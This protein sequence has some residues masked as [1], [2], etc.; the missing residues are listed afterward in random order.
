[1]RLGGGGG[2]GRSS[3]V[4]SGS[5][6]GGGSTLLSIL[7]LL[8]GGVDSDLDGNR[9]TGNLLAFKSGDGLL[10]VLLRANVDEA[11]AL[12]PPGLAPAATDD[13]SRD[14]LETS[15]SEEGGEASI[16]N[17]EA[18][19][20][21]EEHVLGGL[22]G[23]GLTL[24]TRGPGS[25]RLAGA[26]GLLLGLAL[27][28]GLGCGSLACSGGGRSRLLLALRDTSVTIIR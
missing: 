9:T 11:V 7:M 20:G 6:G 27:S 28:T 10:L 26:R 13:A 14:D 12:A 1:M 8:L 19:V 17:A 23:G 21:N 18:K 16:V 15:L 25:T 22:S 5:R 4:G 3:F 2:S 24:S